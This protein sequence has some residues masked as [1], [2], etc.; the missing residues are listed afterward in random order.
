MDVFPKEFPQANA[1]VVRATIEQAAQILPRLRRQDLVELSLIASDHNE[2]PLAILEDCVEQT[3]EPWAIF[4]GTEL[5]GLFGC[6]S[7]PQTNGGLVWLVGT[8]GLT[9]VA[10]TLHKVSKTWLQECLKAYPVLAN[11][12]WAGNTVS[13]RWLKSLGF[14]LETQM[15]LAVSG[16]PFIPFHLERNNQHHQQQQ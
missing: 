5:V 8:E 1:S 9:R 14:V 7:I 6:T 10:K 13:I 11:A 16:A 3:P 12:V 2:S 15:Q 4:H